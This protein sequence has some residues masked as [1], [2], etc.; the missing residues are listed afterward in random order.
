M[1]Q[2][3][4]EVSSNIIKVIGDNNSSS[5]GTGFFVQKGFCVTC[6]HVICRMNNIKIEHNN[7]SFDAYWYSNYSDMENDIA[8][9]KVSDLTTEIN[10]LE[11]AKETTPEITVKV[12]GFTKA[13]NDSLPIGKEVKGTLSTV[14]TKFQ[15]PEEQILNNNATQ[16]LWNKKPKVF[17]DVYQLDTNYARRR[18]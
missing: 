6:H 8:I 10:P 2:S 18:T 3:L 9:L 7:K 4:S 11:C 14:T 12:W 1:G 13:S 5:F 17:M 15:S 16:R